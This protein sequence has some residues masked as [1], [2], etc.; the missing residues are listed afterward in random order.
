MPFDGVRWAD[1]PDEPG[2]YVIYDLD[3]VVYVG[4]AGRNGHGSLQRRLRDH[5]S[6]S[7]VTENRAFL[8]RQADRDHFLAS[9]A[10]VV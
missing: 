6:V 10:P 2:V 3:E 1:V 5:A 9:V 8:A 7:L 4:M